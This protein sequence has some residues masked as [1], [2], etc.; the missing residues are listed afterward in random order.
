M[1]AISLEEV[2]KTFSST[3]AVN[4]LNMEVPEG[5]IC[6]FLGPNG[7]G[8]TT[9]IR[10]ITDILK[11]DRGRIRVLGTENLQSARDRIGYMP[12]ERGL[13]PRMRV[14]S[15]L[16]FLARIKG[17]R[18]SE[19]P[20]RVQASLEM[21]G[22]A[23]WGTKE[24]RELSRGMQRRLEFIASMISDPALLILDEP[25]AGLDPIN[26]DLVKD[27]I[28]R[29]RANGKTILLSTHLMEQ[30]ET[31]C[32]YL[33]LINKGSLVVHGTVRDVRALYESGEITVELDGET[34]FIQAL[35]MVQN[36]RRNGSGIIITMR[37]P[38]HEQELLRALAE[39]AIVRSFRV[40][41]PSLH[42]IFVTAL[43]ERHG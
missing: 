7:A 33:F 41:G 21:M 24:V 8:K 43:G 22:L 39:R 3:N 31:L 36:L 20:T 18:K 13:Y 27:A 14:T 29:L 28:L 32:D 38:G 6:G 12:E 5:S 11:P 40:R 37:E 15:I 4:N 30:A 16:A 34:D 23:E 35:P 17:V 10:M 2:G 19:I 26:V 25:F 1:N 9:T 42:E